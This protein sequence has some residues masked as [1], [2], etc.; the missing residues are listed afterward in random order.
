MMC[1]ALGEMF[2]DGKFGHLRP[3]VSGIFGDQVHGVVVTGKGAGRRRDVVGNDPVTTFAGSFLGGVFDHVIG[4]GSKA[5]DQGR[6]L[7]AGFGNGRQDVG[8]FYHL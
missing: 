2:G 4:F 5:D 7:V 3:R 8:V 1:D 6:T